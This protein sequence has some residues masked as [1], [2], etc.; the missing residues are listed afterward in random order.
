[1][2]GLG[3]IVARV[4][5]C[6]IRAA[7]GLR[8]LDGHRGMEV[9]SHLKGRLG[10][11]MRKH[12]LRKMGA[13]IGRNAYIAGGCEFWFEDAG[14]LKIGEST[15]VDRDCR[16]GELMPCKYEV[17]IGDHARLFDGLRFGAY[18]GPIRI[19]E[20]SRLNFFGVYRG[21]VTVGN[22]VE[23]AHHCV[24]VGAGRDFEDVEKPLLEGNV[25]TKPVV[26]GDSVWIGS[27][28]TIVP[29][30]TIGEHA[31][32][33]ANSVVTRNIPSYCVAAG[34]PARV[35]KR[36]DFDKKEW[37]RVITENKQS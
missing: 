35:I 20:R 15:Q 25:P 24:I 31:V 18:A 37:I 19:G 28:V 17:E 14:L 6:P 23:I 2:S 13:Q 34:C 32:V 9:A 8:M 4:L 11:A 10:S 21:P 16:F 33:G 1:M 5:S 27:N 30:I 3:K 12:L 7:V 36:Y 29:G 22:D 26:I